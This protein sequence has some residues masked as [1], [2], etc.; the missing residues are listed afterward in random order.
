[1]K[2]ELIPID[3]VLVEDRGREDFGAV[4]ELAESI[5]TKGLLH[6]LVVDENTKLIAGERRLRALKLLKWELVPVNRFS[7]L[8]ELMK[9]E[10]ELEENTKR[11]N[12]TWQEESR[13]IQKAVSMRRGSNPEY[14]IENDP[15]LDKMSESSLKENLFLAR[16]AEKFP[17]IVQEKDKSNAVRLAKRLQ[18]KEIRSLMVKAAGSANINV[19]APTSSV[20]SYSIE[21]VT[22]YL[23]DCLEGIRLL[24]SESI[25]LILTDFPFGVDFGNNADFLKR[26]DEVYEDSNDVLLKSLVPELCIEFK[27]VL[28]D[29]AHFYIFY[30]SMYHQEFF[31]EFNK[32][33]KVQRIPLIWNK[34]T[35]GTS[36]APYT[37]YAPN[38]EPIL[39]GWKGLAPRKLHSP[40]YCVLNFD[41][42]TGGDKTHPAEKPL[43][44][45]CYLIQQSTIEGE[46]VLETFSGSGVTLEACLRMS[47]KGIGFE[48]SQRW[49]ELGVERLMNR[50]KGGTDV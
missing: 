35:G 7:D 29:G 5:R 2:V 24:P 33:F 38:Y 43:E 14:R 20:Q 4:G 30:P 12:L 47:R 11:K 39:Y 32:Y 25:D 10:I 34:R 36:F 18:E 13:L 23:Q 1:M 48:L 41:N 21:G 27:R 16:M 26:W 28:K 42:L 17:S 8:D 46:T 6:P 49:Y 50:A 15:L 45:M 3:S 22:L 31:D 19:N 40:G 9:V 37:Y 44:L